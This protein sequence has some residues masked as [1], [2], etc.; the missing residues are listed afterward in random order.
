[1]D[2][3]EKSYVECGKDTLVNAKRASWRIASRNECYIGVG[4]MQ[5][6]SVVLATDKSNG[7]KIEVNGE[8]TFASRIT[9]QHKYS[10]YVV[11]VGTASD[12]N[13]DFLAL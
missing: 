8:S 5:P 13:G 4:C 6:T 10:L 12:Y 7:V 11:V 3:A 2:E 9:S 1:M